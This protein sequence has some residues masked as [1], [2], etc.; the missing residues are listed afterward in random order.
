LIT[1]L[2]V[3]VTPEAVTAMARAFSDSGYQVQSA[4]SYWLPLPEAEMEL[5]QEQSEKVSQFIASLEADEDV[6]VVY[7][8]AV[9]RE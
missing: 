6:I 8:N 9:I 3:F 1:K 7:T 5:D 2:E 4:E